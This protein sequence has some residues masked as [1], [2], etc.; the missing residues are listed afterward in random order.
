M[1]YGIY[2]AYWTHEWSADYESYIPKV[3]DLEFDGVL[4]P[5]HTPLM[6]CAGPWDAGMA[7]ALG[8]MR[9]AF[10]VLERTRI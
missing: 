4:I 2:N 3:K 10:Q 9:A 6:D 5:D 7:F 1:L 8:Y